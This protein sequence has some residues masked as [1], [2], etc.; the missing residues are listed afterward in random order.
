MQLYFPNKK[1]AGILLAWDMQQS[2]SMVPIGMQKHMG[3]DIF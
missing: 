2:V 3:N 1:A